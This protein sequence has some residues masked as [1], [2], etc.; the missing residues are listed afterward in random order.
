MSRTF[1]MVVGAGTPV[2]R[3]PTFLSAKTE[4][5]RLARQHPG[6]EFTLLQSLGTC[7]KSDVKWDTQD[8]VEPEPVV[9][10]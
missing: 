10:F 8:G 2:V 1:W 5:E 3:H 9:P 7:R 4:A 6:Q